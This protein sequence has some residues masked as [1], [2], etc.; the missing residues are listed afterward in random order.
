MVHQIADENGTLRHIILSVMNGNDDG[1]QLDPTVITLPH[2]VFR[3]NSNGDLVSVDAGGDITDGTIGLSQQA[4][5]AS[6]DGCPVPYET[7][8]D[9]RH[10]Q[11]HYHAANMSSPP[12]YSSQSTIPENQ[13]IVVLDSNIY[14]SNIYPGYATAPTFTT[15]LV[16]P[17][18]NKSS[19]QGAHQHS[20]GSG[21]KNAPIDVDNAQRSN[22]AIVKDHQKHDNLVRGHNDRRGHPPLNS[23]KVSSD[24]HQP[25]GKVNV[26]KDIS[27][28]HIPYNSPGRQR[29]KASLT[30]VTRNSNSEAS[31]E[32]REKKSS[33]ASPA[34]TSISARDPRNQRKPVIGDL[35]GTNPKEQSKGNSKGNQKD[36]TVSS[37]D[38]S[39]A[40]NAVKEGSSRN[41]GS[42]T[43]PPLSHTHNDEKI[44]TNGDSVDHQESKDDNAGYT[45]TVIAPDQNPVEADNNQL[46]SS[47]ES[48]EYI[49]PVT[50]N[51]RRS[52]EDSESR[53]VKMK[54][55]KNQNTAKNKTFPEIIHDTSTK[56]QLVNTKSDL[57]IKS[58]LA[59]SPPIEGSSAIAPSVTEIV[60]HERSSSNTKAPSSSSASKIEN[61]S[62][63]NAGLTSNRS[64][65]VKNGSQKNKDKNLT[66]SS[67]GKKH[68]LGN[69]SSNQRSS[70]TD[71][72]NRIV[73][74]SAQD[75][76]ILAHSSSAGRV[77]HRGENPSSLSSRAS[78]HH[79]H[80]H[81]HQHNT[82]SHGVALAGRSITTR[83]FNQVKLCRVK[84]ASMCGRFLQSF[85][86]SNL[87]IASVAIVM[88]SC[89]SMVLALL[90]HV[91]ILKPLTE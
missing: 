15:H 7:T 43:K 28:A 55:K 61:H 86:S 21:H 69:K 75:C 63:R 71:T 36:I 85:L 57:N 70:S 87:K 51:E 18:H 74:G 62:S 59:S 64:S 22:Q 24:R 25:V 19:G 27:E 13:G 73:S 8:G 81:N 66:P 53:S 46:N 6:Y 52:S 44:V 11:Q 48:E 42:E 65:I 77:N 49:A 10:H 76:S 41:D 4:Y 34:T 38:S 91:C 56:S 31:Q 54:L 78:S 58:R 83:L 60:E 29:P 3:V 50:N 33:A 72:S 26:A 12:S 89:F 23:D 82:G 40:R 32:R 5:Y 39:A 88:F 90:I 16:S 20:R 2:G 80:S 17:P 35:C 47:D 67:N 30:Q 79:H 45:P 1:S 14:Q 68:I 9:I 37:R 84:S